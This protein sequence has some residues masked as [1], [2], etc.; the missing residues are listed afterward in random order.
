MKGRSD[1]SGQ[2]RFGALAGII[3]AFCLLALSIRIAGA[4]APPGGWTDEH[5]HSPFVRVVNQ[6]KD[7][8]VNISAQRVVD[9]SRTGRFDAFEEWF[10]PRSDRGERSRQKSLGSGF[11]FRAD[12]YIL[13]NYHVINGADDITIRLSDKM[14][15]PARVVGTDAATDLAVLRIRT[16]HDLPHVPLGDS[17]SLLVGDWVVA[18]GNPFP[19][20][21]LDR[22]V[23]VGVI[24]ATGRKDLFFGDETPTYQNYIQTDASINPGN[25]G[26]PL[27]NLKGEV[28]GINA[29]IASPTGSS[30]GIGFA[31]PVNFA[32]AVIPELMAS[33][34]VSRGWLGIQPRDLQWDD[35]EA[36]GL[37][38]ADGIIINSVIEK[39]PAEQA[40]LRA[41]DVVL[42]LDGT[43]VRDAQHFMQLIWKANVGATVKLDLVRR[44]SQLSLDVRL[45]DRSEFLASAGS[46]SNLPGTPEQENSKYLGMEVVTA[47]PERAE[48]YGVVFNPGV[49]VTEIDETSHAYEKGIRVGMIISEIDHTSIRNRADF[50]EAASRANEDRKPVSLLVYDRRGGTGYFA[51]RPDTR[52]Q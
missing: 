49:I 1:F 33:G 37:Q 7:A 42:K 9:R 52:N 35:V 51:V 41:G 48:E 18:I 10:G 31:I 6:V 12:G 45:G 36:L 13:T 38:S 22:T 21:S 34:T 14:E 17:D 5:G 2:P 32:R 50:A 44:G 40:G 23:T 8:V 46:R 20:Q 24:S 15:L 16:D 39:T 3:A 28:I 27:V 11:I 26:G 47:T 43:R 25:S 4:Q 19:N 29:A 30:V